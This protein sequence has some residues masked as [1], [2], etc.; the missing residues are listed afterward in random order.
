MNLPSVV[1][2]VFSSVLLVNPSSHNWEL[3]V[4][5]RLSI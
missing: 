4:T 5:Q 3:T 1:K 2:K